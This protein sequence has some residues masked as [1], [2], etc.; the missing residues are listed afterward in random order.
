LI[1]Y[2]FVAK[3]AQAGSVRYEEPRI[4]IRLDDEILAWFPDDVNQSGGGNYQ[5]L[6]NDALQEHIAQ[7]QETSDVYVGWYEQSPNSR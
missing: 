6:I 5:T 3:R 7:K 2:V 1:R 4:T